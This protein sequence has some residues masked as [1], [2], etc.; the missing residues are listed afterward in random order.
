MWVVYIR[1]YTVYHYSSGM[2]RQT[3]GWGYGMRWNTG[4]YGLLDRHWI[5]SRLVCKQVHYIMWYAI[6]VITGH[7]LSMVSILPEVYAPMLMTALSKYCEGTGLSDLKVLHIFSRNMII[8]YSNLLC[9][10]FLSLPLNPPTPWL[11]QIYGI[12]A[13]SWETKAIQNTVQSDLDLEVLAL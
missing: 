4:T 10:L 6:L 5:I 7:Y 1:K 3:A 13:T 12:P 11:N 2:R 9:V 8:V